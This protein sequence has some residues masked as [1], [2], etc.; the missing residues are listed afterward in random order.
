MKLSKICFPLLKVKT[1]LRIIF[2]RIQDLFYFVKF[3]IRPVTT[4]E[5]KPVPA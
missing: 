3:V 1:I 4:I 2:G 5:T